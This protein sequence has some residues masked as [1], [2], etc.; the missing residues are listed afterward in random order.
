MLI[1]RIVAGIPRVAPP[2]PRL[3]PMKMVELPLPTSGYGPVIA[4]VRIV[5]VVH[6]AVE[7]FMPAVPGPCSNKQSTSKPVRSVVAVRSTLIGFIVEVPIGALGCHAN[8]DTNLRAP[9][10]CAADQCNAESCESKNFTVGHSF[11]FNLLGPRG[12]GDLYLLA[13]VS[14]SRTR[15]SDQYRPLSL[16]PQMLLWIRLN[17]LT[18]IPPR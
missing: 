17:A 2:I 5:A 1:T 16:R 10:R 12:C 3:I 9:L 13:P 14:L 8:A 18:P 6:M 7:T 4:I 11:S 15:V